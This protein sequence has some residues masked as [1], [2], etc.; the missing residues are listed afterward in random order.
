MYNSRH[1]RWI[2]FALSCWLSSVSDCLLFAFSLLP[3]RRRRRFVDVCFRL[4]DAPATMPPRQYFIVFSHFSSS[5]IYC[6]LRGNGSGL[7]E[8][9]GKPAKKQPKPSATL[10][11]LT[12]QGDKA[13]LAHIHS[14]VQQRALCNDHNSLYGMLIACLVFPL[15]NLQ[16]NPPLPPPLSS[17][18]RS[19][20]L[21]FQSAMRCPN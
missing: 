19:F 16:A 6:P 21:S 2:R 5:F 4:C 11:P 17:P 15:S 1:I 8:T 20:P 10:A 12:A 9:R 3:P 7:V 18:G 14:W 13:P